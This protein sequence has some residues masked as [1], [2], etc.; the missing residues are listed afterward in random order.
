MN[1]KLNLD[2]LAILEKYENDDRIKPKEL[3]MSV[4]IKLL[5]YKGIFDII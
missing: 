3:N 4:T 1:Q 5:I 2:E